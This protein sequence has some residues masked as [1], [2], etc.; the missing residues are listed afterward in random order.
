MANKLYWESQKGNLCRLHAL[1]AYFGS[2]KISETEFKN[3]CEQYNQYIKQYYNETIKSQNYDIF[4]TYSLVSYIINQIEG[5]YCYFIPFNQ[6]KHESLSL[7][8]LLHKSDSFFVF[9]NKHIY[10]VKYHNNKYNKIDSLSG[11]FPVQLSSFKGHKTGFVIPRDTQNLDFD[12]KLLMNKIETYLVK[13]DIKTTINIKEWINNNYNNKLLDDMEVPLAHL[14]QVMIIK[15]ESVSSLNKMMNGFYQNKLN[16]NFISR[17]L[18]RTLFRLN[19]VIK[20]QQPADE[21]LKKPEKKKKKKSKKKQ[22]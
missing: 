17:I 12:K 3:Y 6:L 4:P 16:R 18:P 5:K 9:N 21:L 19:L 10:T 22:K 1:N 15:G 13:N 11:I 20:I 2:K 7:K 14:N 8:E